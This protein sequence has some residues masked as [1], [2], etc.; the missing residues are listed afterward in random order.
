[1]KQK[2]TKVI[3]YTDELN[4]EFS[5][6]VIEPKVIDGSYSYEHN[7]LGARMK[8]LWWYHIVAKPIAWCYLKIGFHHKIVNRKA[9]KEIGKKG[10]FLFGNHTN[11]GADALIPTMVQVRHPKDTYVIVHPNNVSMPVLGKITPYLGALPLPSDAEATKNFL[12]VVKE[13]VDEGRCVMIYPEAH[14]WPYY[15][16]I[17]P[18]SDMSFRYPVQS[19]APVY[20]LTNTYQK[21]RFGKKPRIVT[22]IDGPFYPKEGVSGKA[23]KEDLRNQVYET[24]VARSQNSNIEMI[25]YVKKEEV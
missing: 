18:F 23:A 3:Y 5:D 2:E 10:F 25:R 1:M 11:A 19:K 7:S 13:T 16:K 24:M 6:A 21:R 8:R 20:C 14:I 4:D 22:Y 12:R 9:L 15:T 17:R